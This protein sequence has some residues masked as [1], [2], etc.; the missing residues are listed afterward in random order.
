MQRWLLIVLSGFLLISTTN[1]AD[2]Q[3]AAAFTRA[4]GESLPNVNPYPF[5]D[6][7][8]DCIGNNVIDKIGT[9]RLRKLGIRES[10]VRSVLGKPPFINH[11]FTNQEIEDLLDAIDECIRFIDIWNYVVKN[12]KNAG[13]WLD[14]E[15][16]NEAFTHC[17]TTVFSNDLPRTLWKT[18]FTQSNTAFQ[19]KFKELSDPTTGCFEAIFCGKATILG[20]YGIPATVL[21]G[22]GSILFDYGGGSGGLT[23]N[24]TLPMLSTNTCPFTKS[25]SSSANN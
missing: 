17:V 4:I 10:N 8:A 18:L 25:G 16:I 19:T 13:D 2:A 22:G 1:T 15:E 5:G 24:Y 3:S 6:Q 23:F 20:S 14:T 12:S 7:T 21:P 11:S 9:R